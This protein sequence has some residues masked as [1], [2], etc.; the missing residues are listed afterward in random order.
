MLKLFIK[1]HR[2]EILLAAISLFWLS[3]GLA[4]GAG[5]QKAPQITV[6]RCEC[7]EVEDNVQVA[8]IETATEQR[9]LVKATAYCS[10]EKCCGT[11][12]NN[13]PVDANGNEIVITASGAA[14]KANHTVAVD[15]DVFPFGTV[16]VI[17]G[18]E[19]VAEDTGSAIEGND[20]DIYFDNHQAA[21]E[22]GVQEL[23]A[24]VKG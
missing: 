22:F 14:A 23:V 9:V 8:A 7:K 6:V 18:V 16:L 24:V 3:V 11:W 21:T 10:C 17:D 2:V 20:V 13:R 4:I 5:V 15:P 12:A 1:R 19:Y